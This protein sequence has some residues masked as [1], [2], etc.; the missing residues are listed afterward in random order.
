MRCS[1][2]KNHMNRRGETTEVKK[3]EKGEEEGLHDVTSPPAVGGGKRHLSLK[4]WNVI[5]FSCSL[6]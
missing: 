5:I 2:E 3:R 1:G 4:V 6:S